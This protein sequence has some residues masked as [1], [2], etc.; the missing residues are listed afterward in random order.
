MQASCD[1]KGALAEKDQSEPYLLITG[2]PKEPEQSF[3]VVDQQVITE[4]DIRDCPLTI[5][6]IFFVFN[7]CYTKSLVNVFTL[8]EI[9]LLNLAPKVA[10]IVSNFLSTIQDP[11]DRKGP[12]A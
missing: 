4:V 5:I 10:S 6:S 3:V 9:I 2:T 1:V 11:R 7:I 12:S 8:L